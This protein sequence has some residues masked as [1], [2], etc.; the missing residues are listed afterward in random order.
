MKGFGFSAL[1]SLLILAGCMNSHLNTVPV[2]V[3]SRIAP[4]S[5]DPL[6]FDAVPHH[7]AFKPV[8]AT[9]I[10]RYRVGRFQGVVASEWSHSPDFKR[11]MFKIREGMTFSDG[12]PIGAEE[13]SASLNRTFRILRAK[14]SKAGLAE[15]VESASP[16]DGY[17]EFSFSKPMEHALELLSFGLYSIVSPK[18]YDANSGKWKNPRAATASGPYRISSWSGDRLILELRP[19]FPNDLRHP[20]A[21][22]VIEISSASADFLNGDLV[23]DDSTNIELA[24]THRFSG[25][26]LSGICYVHCLTWA[27][28]NSACADVNQ[29]RTLRSKFYSGLS[30]L[31]TEYIPS[32]FPLT[33]KGISKVKVDKP[34][35]IELTPMEL[36]FR[37]S[38]KNSKIVKDYH[39]TLISLVLPEG[40]G[41]SAIDL[42]FTEL[43]SHLDPE[44]SSPKV[45]LV[46][47]ETSILIDSPVHDVHFMF[48]SKEGV[49]LPDPTGKV[50]RELRRSNPDLQAINQ[51]L[52]D[53][54][55]I[56]PIAHF[57][58]GVW[59][60]SGFDFSLLDLAL[61]PTDLS[62][63]GAP[64]VR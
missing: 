46:Y 63:I 62:W 43:D 44:F 27:H 38:A 11:W 19:D 37:K 31:G 48:E 6:E 50:S 42:P 54:A 26:V 9:L 15:F 57:A 45:D 51:Q 5:A 35:P 16:K 55:I 14:N 3:S 7:I 25:G 13:V 30:K 18:D 61:P 17:V 40:S 10:T 36:R 4:Y 52:W 23:P 29:R 1:G 12:M 47:M 21:A 20:S 59:A 60:K 2:K 49:R 53:D 39:S 41:I 24:S 56:W 32:F 28:R 33:M 34:S 64:R 58:T 8:L 22:P